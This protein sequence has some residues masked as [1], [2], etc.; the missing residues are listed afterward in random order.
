MVGVPRGVNYADFLSLSSGDR[1]GFYLGEH[2]Y[3]ES[4]LTD[5]F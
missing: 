2:D 1:I 4:F 5:G 3:E